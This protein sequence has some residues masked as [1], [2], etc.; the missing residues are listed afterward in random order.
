MSAY[1]TAFVLN[2]ICDT[3]E[4]ERERKRAPLFNFADDKWNWLKHFGYALCIDMKTQ[5]IFLLYLHCQFAKKER[6]SYSNVSLLCEFFFVNSLMVWFISFAVY[7][8]VNNRRQRFNSS[9]EIKKERKK[10]SNFQIRVFGSFVFLLLYY[11]NW[12]KY[13]D[14]V[15]RILFGYNVLCVYFFVCINVLFQFCCYSHFI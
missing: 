1:G 15:E 11:L 6:D 5:R 9:N 13:N 8:I 3:N 10:S 14:Y 7:C 12:V 2:V 4:R